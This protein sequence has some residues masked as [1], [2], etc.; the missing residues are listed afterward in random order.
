MKWIKYAYE[1]DGIL[2]DGSKV[3]DLPIIKLMLIRRDTK[4]LIVGDAL[5]DTGFD[6]SVYS[7]YEI[8]N[9]L[10]GLKPTGKAE[11]KSAAEIIECEIH[12]VEASFASD[13]ASQ[14]AAKGGSSLSVKKLGRIKIYVPT[15]PE[16]LA[17]D[18]LI[19][20]EILNMLNFK[21]NGSYAEIQVYR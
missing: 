16:D 12:E 17:D 14:I 11:L 21:L 8:A 7:N 1:K 6:M 3:P 5:I 10:E 15:N 4:K 9:F 20:R 19:G 18:A 2:P 13:D